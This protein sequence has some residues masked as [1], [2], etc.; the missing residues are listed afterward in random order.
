MPAFAGFLA[1]TTR[2]SVG[3]FSVREAFGAGFL[4]G[5]FYF[6]TIVFPKITALGGRLVKAGSD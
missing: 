3:D 6:A 5:T 4:A 1:G 2:F